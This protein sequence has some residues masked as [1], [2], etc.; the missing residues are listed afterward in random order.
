MWVFGCCVS[1]GG[2]VVCLF[3][4]LSGLTSEY[5]ALLQHSP[6]PT[7]LHTYVINNQL[8]TDTDSGNPTV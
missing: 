6:T 7:P 4:D 3:V 1:D 2:D 8:G 5:I